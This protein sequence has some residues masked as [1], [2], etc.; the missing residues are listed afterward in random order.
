MKKIVQLVALLGLLASCSS[1]EPGLSNNKLTFNGT[2]YPVGQ[3]YVESIT[4]GGSTRYYL[5]FLSDDI[6]VNESFDYSQL[7][8]SGPFF[9]MELDSETSTGLPAGSYAQANYAVLY[10]LIPSNWNILANSLTLKNSVSVEKTGDQYTFTFE[11]SSPEN[12]CTLQY[13]GSL[14]PIYRLNPRP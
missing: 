12:T 13:A 2:T 10:E 4:N 7:E 8:G 3:A 9:Y 6:T 11:F 5:Y 1:D 14:L